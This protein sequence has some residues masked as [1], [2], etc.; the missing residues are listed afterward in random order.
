M[1][2]VMSWLTEW[3]SSGL[4]PDAREAVRGDAEERGR[5][6]VRDLCSVVLWRQWEAWTTGGPWVALLVVVA[7]LGF[8]LSVV[9][10]QWAAGI[11]IEFWLYVQNWTSG[12]LASPGAR[13]DLLSVI[14]TTGTKI[15]ALVLWSWTI[16]YVLALLSR[17]ASGINTVLLACMVFAGT[18]GTTTMGVLNPAN[19]AVFSSAFYRLGVPFGVRVLLVMVPLWRCARHERR[20]ISRCGGRQDAR[21]RPPSSRP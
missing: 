9:S 7:P 12:Y 17:R 15:V 3:L 8:V 6:V 4:P 2:R 20:A 16:G 19:A 14:A 11:S 5:P 10:R 13:L 18:A 1:R 21:S